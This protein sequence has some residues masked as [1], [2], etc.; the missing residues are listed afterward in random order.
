[1][2]GS[3]SKESLIERVTRS[4][5][6]RKK[7]EATKVLKSEAKFDVEPAEDEFH[8]DSDGIDEK[9]PKASRKVVKTVKRNVKDEKIEAGNKEKVKKPARK[10][11]AGED[12]K[13]EK[14]QLPVLDIVVPESG[15]LVPR[16][17][18]PSPWNGT[19]KY[20]NKVYLGAH[21][22]AAGMKSRKKYYRTFIS[23]EFVYL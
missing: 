18:G 4:S 20:T 11:S 6:K 23:I 2:S 1:M 17:D 3:S 22:S 10:A 12:V 15:K 7:P 19:I 8:R 16:C 5:V 14:M 13:K 21:V 9:K